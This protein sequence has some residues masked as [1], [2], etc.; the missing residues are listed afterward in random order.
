MR[1][2]L[3]DRNDENNRSNKNH[4]NVEKD[5]NADKNDRSDRNTDHD[6]K[7]KHGNRKKVFKKHEDSLEVQQL[8][9]R[10]EEKASKDMMSIYD[11]RTFTNNIYY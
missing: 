1:N 3:N 10:N 8:P 6:R 4:K 7:D 5:R 2:F 9:D 11:W